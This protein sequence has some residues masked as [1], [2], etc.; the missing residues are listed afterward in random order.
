MFWCGCVLLEFPF[1]VNLPGSFGYLCIRT[2][3]TVSSGFYFI[4]N[5]RFVFREEE[6]EEES[7]RPTC[8]LFFLKILFPRPLLFSWEGAERRLFFP[9]EELALKKKKKKNKKRKPRRWLTRCTRP[10]LTP[11]SISNFFTIRLFYFYLFWLVN[12]TRGYYCFWRKESKDQFS[13]KISF[14]DFFHWGHFFLAWIMQLPG[15][16]CFFDSFSHSK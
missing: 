10:R 13:L 4:K 2:K 5:S 12:I 1:S 16:D 7:A 9:G 14:P 8:W 11:L 6:E 3:S 15:M